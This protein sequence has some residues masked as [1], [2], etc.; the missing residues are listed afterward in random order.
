MATGVYLTTQY[1]SY[2]EKNNRKYFYLETTGDGWKVGLI[3]SEFTSTSAH[4]LELKPLPIL[5]D[6]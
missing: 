2:Y 5:S 1:G 6:T 3:P 4:I